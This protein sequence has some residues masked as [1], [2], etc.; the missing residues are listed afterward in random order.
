MAIYRD[1]FKKTGTNANAITKNSSWVGMYRVRMSEQEIGLYGAA[2]TL[3]IA[4]NSSQETQLRFYLGIETNTNARTY[5]LKAGAVKNI[6]VEDG[7]AFYGFDIMDK[8]VATD[9]AASNIVWT[10][11]K[12]QQLSE[13]K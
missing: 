11:G 1:T 13:G 10:M 8:D 3:S 9:V 7:I 12:V 6:N 4:N 5:Q 2:N